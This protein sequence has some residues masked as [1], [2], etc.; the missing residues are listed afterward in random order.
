MLQVAGHGLDD[1]TSAPLIDAVGCFYK[2]LQV[3]VE[4]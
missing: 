2:P 1:P 3:R 4:G